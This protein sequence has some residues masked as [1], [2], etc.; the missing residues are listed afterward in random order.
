MCFGESPLLKE[1][2]CQIFC[3]ATTS[4]S[5][6]ISC[7]Q[8]L[9]LFPIHIL[10]S[11]LRRPGHWT[12]RVVPG[13]FGFVVL[14]S[15]LAACLWG[16][17]VSGIR[18]NLTGGSMQYPMKLMIAFVCFCII[19]YCHISGESMDVPQIFTSSIWDSYFKF[20]MCKNDGKEV[21]TI[22]LHQKHLASCFPK[23]FYIQFCTS[24]VFQYFCD[25][26]LLQFRRFRLSN[27][28]FSQF[29]MIWIWVFPKIMVPPNHPF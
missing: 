4:Y 2:V 24:I 15:W 22:H 3:W 25:F 1:D 21:A 14:P 28:H 16:V 26:F 18:Q 5:L 7:A 20:A 11:W 12:S 6:L 23:K 13:P 27:P 17:W 19:Y 29:P 10:V 8:M 9:G